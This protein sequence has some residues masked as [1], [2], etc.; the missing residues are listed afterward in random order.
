MVSTNF[1]GSSFFL[2]PVLIKPPPDY[3]KVIEYNL[4]QIFTFIYITFNRQQVVR[5]MKILIFFSDKPLTTLG[6]KM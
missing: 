2:S 6:L 3:I 4:R 5:A 1:S